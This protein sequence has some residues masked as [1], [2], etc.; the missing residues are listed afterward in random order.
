MFDRFTTEAKDVLNRARQES[1]RLGHAYL[2]PEHM[3][4]GMLAMPD[5]TGV[6]LLRE[7][8]V[9]VQEL[10]AELGRIVK[11]G[12]ILPGTI[13]QIPFTASAKKVLELAMED[14]SQAH[15]DTLTVGHVLI[16]L[17]SVGGSIPAAVLADRGVGVELLRAKVGAR[18]I[19]DL[20]DRPPMDGGRRRQVL[21]EAIAL[22]VVL[23]ET[24]AA[25]R[26]REALIR[27]A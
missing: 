3:L 1:D 14:M 23:G 7:C 20:G 27:L 11:P 25:E 4:M 8:G 18:W 10:R 16:A 17:A 6:A 12:P 19:G 24:D 26:V 2:G 13:G 22:L 21:R 9:D 5:S 15:H